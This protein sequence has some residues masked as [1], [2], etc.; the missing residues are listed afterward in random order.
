MVSCEVD[1]M[2]DNASYGILLM[3]IWEHLE[4]IGKF[5]KTTRHFIFIW[6]K[7]TFT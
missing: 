1:E 3:I 7:Y 6:N 2:R 4:P 5:E